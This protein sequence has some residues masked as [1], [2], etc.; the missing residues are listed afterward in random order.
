M[1]VRCHLPELSYFIQSIAPLESEKTGVGFS[2]M[3]S[4]RISLRS[5]W[6]H[7]TL[8]VDHLHAS[9][10]AS[11]W[12]SFDKVGSLISS[13]ESP[14][15]ASAN[16]MCSTAGV[17]KP[18]L[19]SLPVSVMTGPFA[20]RTV[21]PHKA[22]QS[23]QSCLFEASTSQDGCALPSDRNSMPQLVSLLTTE[24]H[25]VVCMHEALPCTIACVSWGRSQYDAFDQE[26]DSVGVCLW[27]QQ[28]HGIVGPPS[29]SRSER[30]IIA[31]RLARVVRRS[32]YS[33]FKNP[34]TWMPGG[35]AWLRR[36]DRCR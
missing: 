28:H 20:R 26:S 3:K 32:T 13:R 8:A 12:R 11:F 18:V 6:S 33:T 25:L 16:A 24:Y 5:C 22:W 9:K 14:C 34:K 36:Q 17:P 1:I 21:Y 7:M 10:R 23:F 29:L 15:I 35:P 31:I 30:Y 2:T 27:T 4:R 19:R